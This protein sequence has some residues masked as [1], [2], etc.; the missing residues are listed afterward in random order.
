MRDVHRH[1]RPLDHRFHQLLTFLRD[2]ETF[3]SATDG[4]DE[5][6]TGGGVGEVGGDLLEQDGRVN[7]EEGREDRED[8]DEGRGEVPRSCGRSRR[9]L[10]TP[11]PSRG[12]PAHS[13]KR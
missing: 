1:D 12:G 13:R 9:C 7:E 10:A 4:V 6:E 3:E 8:R 11:C 2:A 5:A